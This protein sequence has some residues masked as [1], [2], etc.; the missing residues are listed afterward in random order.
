MTLAYRAAHAEAFRLEPDHLIL[1]RADLVGVV[2][3]GDDRWPS[4]AALE[5][6]WLDG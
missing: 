3:C 5:G 1:Q 4:A 2:I 6:I